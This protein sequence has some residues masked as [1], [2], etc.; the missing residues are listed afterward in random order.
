MRTTASFVV[1]DI[2]LCKQQMLNWANRFGICC[3][4]DSCGYRDAYSR[5]DCLAAAGAEKMFLPQHN[6]LSQLKDFT[7]EC[8]DWLFGHIGY[9]LKNEIEALSSSHGDQLLF[10]DLFFFQPQVVMYLQG[11]ALTIESL[12][13]SPGDI[14]RQLLSLPLPDAHDTQLAAPVKSR[15]VKQQYLDIIAK[16]K[17]HIL[18][19]DCYE[20]NFCQ[21]FFSEH[22]VVDAVALYKKLSALSPSPFSAFYKINDKYALCASPERYLQKCGSR[23]ISQPVKGTS[24]RNLQDEAAD[25]ALKLHLQNSPKNRIENVM[26]TDLVRNDL[27]RICLRGSVRVP[28]L[29]GVYTYP[30]VHQM[31]TTVEGKVDKDISIADVLQATFPHGLDD[32]RAK[33]QS[34]ATVGA[35]R[36]FKKRLVCGKYRLHNAR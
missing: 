14:Y 8:K 26:I 22:A 15:L 36:K 4:M 6:R 3:F 29:F 9:D 23:I 24:K 1:D 27:S 18:R 33:A 31:I 5:F 25:R 28:E 11:N 17:Q 12:H 35:I 20:I 7:N 19:G 16:L 30:Q 34:N 2:F 10:P 13:Q 21:E 32:G